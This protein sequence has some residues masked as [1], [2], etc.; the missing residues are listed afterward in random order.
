MTSVCAADGCTKPVPPHRRWFCSTNC[1]ARTRVK[2]KRARACLGRFKIV[3]L[4]ASA[5]VKIWE[6]VARFGRFA[7]PTSQEV[8]DCFASDSVRFRQMGHPR[9]KG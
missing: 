7:V 3:D 5:E 9:R 4:T 2:R 1:G 6:P 8:A